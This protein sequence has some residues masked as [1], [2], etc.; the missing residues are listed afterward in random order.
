MRVAVRM[1]MGVPG[2]MEPFRYHHR[3]LTLALALTLAL[4]LTLTLTRTL[5]GLMEP[6]RYHHRGPTIR[7]RHCCRYTY[8]CPCI[9]TN[10]PVSSPTPIDASIHVPVPALECDHNSRETHTQYLYS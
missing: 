3:G 7:Y 6:F 8:T 10:I 4:T 9:P 1:S 5:I 2:L